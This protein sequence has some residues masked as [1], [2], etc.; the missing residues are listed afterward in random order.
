MAKINP[1]RA[2]QFVKGPPDG[3]TCVY[4]FQKVGGCGSEYHR[5]P[6]FTNNKIG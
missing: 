3:R 5:E 1:K 4:E 2:R 6:L